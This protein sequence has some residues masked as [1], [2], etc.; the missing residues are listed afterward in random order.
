MTVLWDVP[1]CSLVQIDR[2]FRDASSNIITLMME[3]ASTSETSV[4][5]YRTTRRNIPEDSNLHTRCRENLKSHQ[6]LS[7]LRPLFFRRFSRLNVGQEILV[8]VFNVEW[9][10]VRHIVQRYSYLLKSVQCRM[11]CQCVT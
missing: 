3:A 4:N 11:A 1:P 5:F 9:L 6:T 7:L 10:S 2:R 8:I